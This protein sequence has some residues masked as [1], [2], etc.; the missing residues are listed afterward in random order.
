M[1]NAVSRRIAMLRDEIF[2]IE[3]SGSR[4][5]QLR[6]VPIL[7]GMALAMMTVWPGVSAARAADGRSQIA[8]GGGPQVGRSAA[9]GRR[10]GKGPGRLQRGH[11]APPARRR[12]VLQPGVRLQAQGRAR[13]GGR[14]SGSSPQARCEGRLGLF[15]PRLGLRQD[16]AR[17]QGHCGHDGADSALSRRLLGSPETRH[18]VLPEGRL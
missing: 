10:T 4:G 7:L 3:P 16:P 11:P 9:G 8:S 2:S 14:R 12:G 5:W 15:R 6:V 1:G 18:D 13:Q 17:G